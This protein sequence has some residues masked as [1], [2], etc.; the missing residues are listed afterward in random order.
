M[1]EALVSEVV[2]EVWASE[3]K[4]GQRGSWDCQ[5]AWELSSWWDG[6]T[7]EMSGEKLKQAAAQIL[8]LGKKPFHTDSMSYQVLVDRREW[9]GSY[10]QVVLE[11]KEMEKKEM[12]MGRMEG[13]WLPWQLVQ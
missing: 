1:V 13:A 12:E 2:V 4:S 3:D 9:P 11:E 5:G 7:E 6:E 8:D 10:P